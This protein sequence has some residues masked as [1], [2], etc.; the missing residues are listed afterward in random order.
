MSKLQQDLSLADLFAHFCSP[1][2]SSPRSSLR[3]SQFA[4][5]KRESRVK[6]KFEVVD[7]VNGKVLITKTVPTASGRCV[8]KPS[9]GSSDYYYRY[10]DTHFKLSK[11]WIRTKGGSNV[12]LK[13]RVIVP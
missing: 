10:H 2:C 9:K 12:R 8:I 3:S 7:R 5:L 13:T 11:E 4:Q 6:V 1:L